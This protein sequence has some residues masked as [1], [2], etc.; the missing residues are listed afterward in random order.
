MDILK[1]QQELLKSL[2][3]DQ[4]GSYYHMDDLVF[5]TTAGKV[6]W[7]IHE[8]DLRVRIT[9]A[10]VMFPLD[11]DGIVH[12][13]NLLVGTDE[14]RIGGTVRKYRKNDPLQDD[15]YVSTG[16]LKYFNQPT[17]YQDDDP[18][19]VIVVTEDIYGRGEQTLAGIV[20]PYKMKE[21]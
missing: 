13:D 10:Q 18:R 7:F 3:K 9:G 5:V 4:R 16:L 11:L 19:D 8:D 20:M 14:Y 21:E 17:L 12:P 15:V 6:G 2:V 1:I